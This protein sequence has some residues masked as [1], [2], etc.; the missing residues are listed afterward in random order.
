M[1]KTALT[2]LLVFTLGSIGLAVFGQHGNDLPELRRELID[3][4]ETAYTNGDT[5]TLWRMAE[6][7]RR[8]D[9]LNR[10][11]GPFVSEAVGAD[12]V[13]IC[14]QHYNYSATKGICSPNSASVSEAP[15]HPFLLT[16]PSGAT[17]ES[18]SGVTSAVWIPLPP[19]GLGPPAISPPN[20]TPADCHTTNSA[21]V[22]CTQAAQAACEGG[23]SAAQCQQEHAACY[24]L[25]AEAD[26]VC[27]D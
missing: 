14:P 5:E 24:P 7:E 8:L 17:E 18:P 3:R 23:L 11:Q 27:D 21:A 22:A 13:A 9:R 16:V 19:P 25:W 1:K 4:I 6:T 10:G 20:Y 26:L 2:I 12:I 15:V